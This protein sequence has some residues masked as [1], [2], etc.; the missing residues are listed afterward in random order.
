MPAIS[1]VR[2]ALEAVAQGAPVALEVGGRPAEVRAIRETW[3]ARVASPAREDLPE[4]QGGLALR[5]A[6]STALR[7]P[8][9]LEGRAERG[10]ATREQALLRAARRSSP[11]RSR[12]P[13]VAT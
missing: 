1:T 11:V 6:L 5:E 2:V 10:A 13:T 12:R 4:E 3:R 7:T 8:G 9:V